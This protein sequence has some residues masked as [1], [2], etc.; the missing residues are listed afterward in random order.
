MLTRIT[1]PPEYMDPSGSNF[2]VRK[3]LTTETELSLL[4]KT[5]VLIVP[6]MLAQLL[7]HQY[8]RDCLL[9]EAADGEGFSSLFC[10]FSRKSCF[11]M[12]TGC[13]AAASDT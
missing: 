1:A 13:W 10:N 4:L 9:S 11:V 3:S 12:L 5:L 7:N 6:G 8:D 2:L